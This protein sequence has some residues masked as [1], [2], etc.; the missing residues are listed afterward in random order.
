[1]Q[2]EGYAHL[3]LGARS[4]AEEHNP[5]AVDD[6]GLDSAHVH[7]FA[8]V[9]YPHHVVVR[10]AANLMRAAE[11]TRRGGET[12]ARGGRKQKQKSVVSVFLGANIGRCYFFL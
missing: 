4:F 12:G 2:N 7:H 6:V 10:R 8:H 3:S 11:V 9:L 1:M 5:G